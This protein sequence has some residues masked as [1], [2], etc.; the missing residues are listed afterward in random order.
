MNDAPPVSALLDLSGR[1]ALVTGSGRGLGQAIARRLA[2]AGA[3]VAIHYHQ[4]ESGA[5]ELAEEL[6]TA[7]FQADLTREEEV[8]AL[9]ESV[10]SAHSRIDIVVNNA[11]SY[12][13]KALLEM[14]LEEWDAV[15]AANL[16]SA[17]LCVRSAAREMIA[18]ATGGAIVNIATIEAL[19]P[20]TESSHY[21]TAKAGLLMLTRSAAL[22]LGPQGI[23]VNA[24]S[25]GLIDRPGIEVQW[26]E[27]VAAWRQAAPLGRLG[28]PEDVADACLFL[29]SPAARWISGANL[30]VDGGASARPIF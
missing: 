28:Q 29:V 12:P 15:Q 20:G 1:V 16:R 11:G 17:F 25:P 8:E 2:E 26:P 9:F 7:A 4:S 3:T 18:A 6:G 23:R 21:S 14:T 27:G 30:V 5:R 13:S 10:K 19:A 22:E 24:V